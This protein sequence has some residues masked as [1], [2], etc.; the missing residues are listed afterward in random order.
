MTYLPYFR[1][2]NNGTKTNFRAQKKTKNCQVSHLEIIYEALIKIQ[3]I[4][5]CFDSFE[6]WDF[7][8]E[9]KQL[10]NCSEVW[11]QIHSVKSVKLSL[12]L[13]II[14]NDFKFDI[15]F[16]DWI[17][18]QFGKVFSSQNICYFKS[19]FMLS[20]HSSW[21][22]MFAFGLFSLVLCRTRRCSLVP[23]WSCFFPR[24]HALRRFLA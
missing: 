9:N 6:T 13:Q 10:K 2:E 16:Q 17:I 8:D 15:F 20:V 22:L 12:I 18:G 19:S 24:M 7:R 3:I 5:S 21:V 14:D 1:Q 23:L 11:K 4:F